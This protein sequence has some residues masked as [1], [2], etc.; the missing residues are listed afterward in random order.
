MS[1]ETT[2]EVTKKETN[3]RTKEIEQVGADFT[4]LMEVLKHD[5][6]SESYNICLAKTTSDFVGREHN[7]N[8]M[9]EAL[10]D[11][12]YRKG[13]KFYARVGGASALGVVAGV[14][15]VIAASAA[16]AAIRGDSSTEE[17]SPE[18]TTDGNPFADTSSV[19][20]SAR[21]LK[22]AK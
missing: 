5:R 1:T 9:S 16:A 22:A 19:E 13:W 20:A 6:G 11:L 4:A 10:N 2:K 7:S 17:T 18:I 15:A 21:P 8:A 14:G 3:K 12:S